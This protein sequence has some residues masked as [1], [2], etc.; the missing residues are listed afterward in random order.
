MSDLIV[1]NAIIK[2]FVLCLSYFCLFDVINNKSYEK[3]AYIV[4][5]SIEKKKEILHRYLLIDKETKQF[6]NWQEITGNT[7]NSF[8]F[9]N[10]AKDDGIK[11]LIFSLLYKELSKCI[12]ENIIKDIIENLANDEHFN[13][14]K[15]EIKVDD[16]KFIDVFYTTEDE[17]SLYEYCEKIL[18][19]LYESCND[20]DG[21]NYKKIEN[22]LFNSIKSQD[23]EDILKTN[24][25]LDNCEK[26]S[27]EI[28]LDSS[29]DD[30][31]K[32][33]FT[34]I[35]FCSLF[36]FKNGE[37]LLD[38]SGLLVFDNEIKS[39]DKENNFYVSG[40]SKLLQTLNS[41]ESF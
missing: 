17:K 37:K 32:Y 8:T 5:G 28:V 29:N 1:D 35:L 38:T 20:E 14:Q 31:W 23:Y 22:K 15:Y 18:N 13:A 9:Q 24:S 30:K 25:I 3:E 39:G 40:D 21:E 36:G 34:L 26:Y 12:Y 19:K 41:F 11:D 4:D 2:S 7:D 16:K 27:K 6:L 10:S 33:V